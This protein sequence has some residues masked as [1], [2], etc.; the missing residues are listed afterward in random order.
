MKRVPVRWPALFVLGILVMLTFTVPGSSALAH[1]HTPLL[2]PA[3]QHFYEAV[4]VSEGIDWFDARDAAESRTFEGV[5][6]HLVT[7]TSAQE[8]RFI[9]RNFPE[10][11]TRDDGEGLFPYW[12]GASQPFGSPTEEDWEWVTGEPFNDYTNWAA[13]EPNDFQGRDEDCLLPHG[14]P[15]PGSV[16]WA[17]N[18]A[19]CDE[20]RPLGYVVEYDKRGHFK[21]RR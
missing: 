7:I 20:T 12:Y 18:D 19:E 8:D 16:P 17:W 15:A 5:Q 1:S 21:H 4:T 9:A 11:V 2:N 13:G 10:A 14:N 6:G 3:N